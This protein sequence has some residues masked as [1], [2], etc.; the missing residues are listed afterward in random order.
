MFCVPVW[1]ALDRHFEDTLRPSFGPSNVAP[2]NSPIRS[3]LR[4]TVAGK[5]AALSF[6]ICTVSVRSGR[7]IRGSHRSAAERLCALMPDDQGFPT[8]IGVGRS[9]RAVVLIVMAMRVKEGWAVRHTVA[10]DKSRA[11]G[12]S[13]GF[14]PSRACATGRPRCADRFNRVEF[15]FAYLGGGRRGG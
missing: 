6:R 4:D 11:F 12:G 13:I 15:L 3:K 8:L 7:R 2:T 5:L 9:P 1:A 10:N 14:W